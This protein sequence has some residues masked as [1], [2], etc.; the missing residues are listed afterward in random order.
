MQVPNHIAFVVDGNRR[1][2]E[3]KGM[4]P[5][6]GHVKGSHTFDKTIEWIVELG[7]P[8][9]SVYAL[10]TENLNRPK[11]ELK[12]LYDVM[13][14]TLERWLQNKEFFKKYEIKVNFFGDL[15][16]LP[17][18]MMRLARK[19]M[20][21]TSGYK[22]K[23]VNILLAYGAKLEITNAVK[24]LLKK[25]M[26]SGRIQITQKD[27]ENSLMVNSPVDLVIRTGGKNRLSNFL[28]WQVA[29]AD[30]YTTNVLWPDFTRRELIKAI[31]W[32]NDVQKNYGL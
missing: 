22:K 26:A 28:L 21:M 1:W 13:C 10:S 25:A 12:K 11:S 7:V 30:I 15:N 17:M 16:R 19:M 18:R 2:A 14:D 32:W 6:E 4:R 9:I 31:K 3:E 8:Q 20:K 24:F 5:W 29:Y 23:I 27:V